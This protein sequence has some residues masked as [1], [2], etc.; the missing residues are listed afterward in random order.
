[1]RKN[2]YIYRYR[3]T[4]IKRRTRIIGCLTGGYANGGNYS[5][6]NRIS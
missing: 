5:T 6:A 3:D 2:I 1:M 4:L